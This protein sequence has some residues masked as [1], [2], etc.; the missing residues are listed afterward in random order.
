MENGSLPD[1]LARNP[2]VDRCRLVSNTPLKVQKLS[3]L[4]AKCVQVA[5]GL[6]YLHSIGMV[7]PVYQYHIVVRYLIMLIRR[8]MVTLKRSENFACSFFEYLWAGPIGKC[9][10]IFMW[11][12]QANRLRQHNTARAHARIRANHEEKQHLAALDSEYRYY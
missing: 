3:D 11:C 1:Y 4:F 12:G 5:E 7:R 10:S 9:L 8:Y 2:S 6:N